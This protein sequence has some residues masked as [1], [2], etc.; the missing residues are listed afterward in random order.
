MWTLDEKKDA[1]LHIM[2]KFE[3][4]PYLVHIHNYE[5]A[6]HTIDGTIRQYLLINLQVIVLIHEETVAPHNIKWFNYARRPR[7]APQETRDWWYVY[8]LQGYINVVWDKE[9]LLYVTVLGMG[10]FSEHMCLRTMEDEVQQIMNH[11]LEPW[12]N[13]FKYRCRWQTKS[14]RWWICKKPLYK[15]TPLPK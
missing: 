2:Y 14:Q 10:C 5:R 3:K 13:I 1:S 7:Y 9:S 6:V 15:S 4:S 12:W 8:A 11:D